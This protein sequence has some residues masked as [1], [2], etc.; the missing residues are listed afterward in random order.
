M[1]HRHGIAHA[2]AIERAREQWKADDKALWTKY[3]GDSEEESE[4]EENNEDDKT[5]E[6]QKKN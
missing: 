2:A 6:D 4:S 3:G 5:L 1:S